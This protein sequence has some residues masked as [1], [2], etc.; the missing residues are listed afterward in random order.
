M[1]VDTI[2]RFRKKYTLALLCW[3]SG[4][5]F[6]FYNAAT[7]TEYT[8][9]VVALLGLFASADVAEKTVARPTSTIK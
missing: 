8:Y 5:G 9:F 7:M 6:A 2:S 3:A 1:I 4:T